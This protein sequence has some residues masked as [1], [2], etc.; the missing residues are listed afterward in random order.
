MINQRSALR[1]RVIPPS[2]RTPAT[3]SLLR[4]SKTQSPMTNLVARLA[5]WAASIVQRLVR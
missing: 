3:H 1:H 2:L 5:R 4:Y